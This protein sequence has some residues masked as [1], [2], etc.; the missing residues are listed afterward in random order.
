MLPSAK[1]ILILVIVIS[2]IPC[3]VFVEARAVINYSFDRKSLIVSLY[4]GINDEDKPII[5]E[6]YLNRSLYRVYYFNESYPQ[7]VEINIEIKGPTFISVRTY[8]KIS[9]WNKADEIYVTPTGISTP[10]IDL[11]REIALLIGVSVLLS[12]FLIYFRR[13][14]KVSK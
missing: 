14:P 5:L 11:N 3:F 10:K 4:T 1:T 7:F 6:V 9:G 12:A 8:D 2:A 13:S